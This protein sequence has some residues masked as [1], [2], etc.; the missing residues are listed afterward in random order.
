MQVAE[1]TVCDNDMIMVKGCKNTRAVT[2]GVTNM[3]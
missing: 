3:Q 1:E 2:G